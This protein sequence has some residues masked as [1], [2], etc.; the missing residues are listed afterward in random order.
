MPCGGPQRRE[1]PSC[2]QVGAETAPT[3]LL[4]RAPLPLTAPL[5]CLC[6][7][8][9]RSPLSAHACAALSPCF[10]FFPLQS[11]IGALL[12]DGTVPSDVVFVT[13]VLVVAC[14]VM[15]ARM[16]LPTAWALALL[17]AGYL[18]QDLA[19]WLAEEP[20]MQ[21]ATW[22]NITSNPLSV[23][24]SMFAEHVFYLLPLVVATQ[25][26]A[27][28]ALMGTPFALALLT[29][30]AFA[31]DSS[32]SGTPFVVQT[33]RALFGRLAVPL[34]LEHLASVR[35][36]AMDQQPP[37]DKTSHWWVSDL[38]P[39]ARASFQA[40]ESCQSI[41]ELFATKFS[42]DEYCLDVV[43]GMNELY[44]SG[45]NRSGTS[46]Q[47]FYSEHIDGPFIWF[48]F[49]SVYRC[50]VGMDTNTEISTVFRNA[51]KCAQAGD[52]L[53]FD[54][55]REPHRIENDESTPN[56]QHR[57]VLKL[58]YCV[59]PRRLA[60]LGHILAWLTTRYNQLFRALFL[61]TLVPSGA[62][63]KV[64]G[65]VGVNGGTQLFNAVNKYIGSANLLYM[66]CAAHAAQCVGSPALF[67]AATQFVHYFRYMTTYYFRKG[68]DFA[69]FK[70]DA[71]FFKSQTLLSLAILGVLHQIG[72]GAPPVGVRFVAHNWLALVMVVTGYG[73]SVAATNALGVDGTYFGIELGV[74]KADYGFVRQFPYGTIPH[75]MILGQVSNCATR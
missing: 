6:S 61:L 34:E 53:A 60:V 75:P 51:R 4:L 29:Y 28:Q 46:D 55:N 8:A 5:R 22:G 48:P 42:S 26:A 64:L 52:V 9:L 30:G 1:V 37:R 27:V 14:W 65:K 73:I 25:Q 68:A 3:R 36:W 54:F 72:D 12:W 15:A 67:L 49:A 23:C 62:G 32:A 39:G 58:H 71:L 24:A 41:K 38:G 21:A 56:Q 40:L 70:R 35:Q 66:I 20:T 69:V 44:I 59:Y 33:V 7:F 74:V 19:H 11:Y 45:P 31:V 50:I 17:C 18:G 47:V 57:V 43:P 10:A 16:N 13:S 2:C 63:T